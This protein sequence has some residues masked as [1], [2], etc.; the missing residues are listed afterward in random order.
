MRRMSIDQVA[1]SG[2]RVGSSALSPSLRDRPYHRDAPSVRPEATARV[3]RFFRPG[4]ESDFR[5]I[6]TAG[7]NGEIRAV[8]LFVMIVRPIQPGERSPAARPD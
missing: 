6:G 7:K 8:N 4:E 5:R 2:L 1:E 3:Y